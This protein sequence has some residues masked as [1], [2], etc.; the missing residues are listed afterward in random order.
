MSIIKGTLTQSAPNAFTQSIV[1]TNIQVDGKTGWAISGFR[2]YN[3]T[4][5]SNAPN[6][7]R[8][9]VALSTVNTQTAFNSL[10]ELARVAW[11]SVYEP[12][13]SATTTSMLAGVEPIKAAILLE[14]RLTVQPQIFVQVTSV[15][16]NVAS[17]LF[18]E[19]QYE[20]IKLSDIELL[21]LLV[22][23]A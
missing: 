6:D 12:G 3:E 15:G 5:H 4:L 10:D 11:G 7:L 2:V 14:A 17:V 19:V 8:I 1:D 23:G 18:F 21:R 20:L 13:T 22:G 9:A 16:S